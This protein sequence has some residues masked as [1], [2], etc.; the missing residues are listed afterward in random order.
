MT[1]RLPNL[2][3]VL[4]LLVMGAALAATGI[5]WARVVRTISNSRPV[6]SSLKATSVVWGDLVF[7]SRADLTHWLHAHGATYVRWSINHPAAR[8]RLEHRAS[9]KRAVRQKKLPMLT[10]IASRP[11]PTTA[12]SA[13]SSS[14]FPFERTLVG[15]L[16]LLAAACAL[17]A[18]LP[19]AL[20][21]RYPALA[22]RIVPHRD[23]F[24]AGAAA[25]VIGIV[26]GVVLT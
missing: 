2:R 21:Y 19:A 22:R 7:Q 14:G 10:V 5:V 4:V 18:S 25:L 23:V 20:Q 12:A 6:A 8:D 24:L 16:A 15:L 1:L 11:H 17:A 9:A 13:G 3:Q 26:A